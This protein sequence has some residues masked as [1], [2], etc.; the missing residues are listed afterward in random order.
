MIA[1]RGHLRESEVYEKVQERVKGPQ[2]AAQFLT[3]LENMATIY[4]AIFNPEHECR[5]A[6]PDTIR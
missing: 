6:Y 5:N 1:I 4:V 3:Q 2:S